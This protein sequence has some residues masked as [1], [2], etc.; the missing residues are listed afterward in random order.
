M[1]ALEILGFAS[2]SGRYCRT[3]VSISFGVLLLGGADDFF[4]SRRPLQG[5]RGLRLR[6]YVLYLY[7]LML[8]QGQTAGAG[9]IGH[10]GQRGSR[11]WKCDS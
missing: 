3:V 8:G 9:R 2:K 10:D 4:F 5:E 1:L 11:N 6:A 7:R